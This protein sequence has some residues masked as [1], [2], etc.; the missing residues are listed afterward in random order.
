VSGVQITADLTVSSLII[1]GTSGDI[2]PSFSLNLTDIK[3]ANYA[4]GSAILDAFLT[5]PGGAT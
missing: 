4:G 3:A 2:N 5:A 1:D